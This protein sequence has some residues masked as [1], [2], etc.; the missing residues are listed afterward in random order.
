MKSLLGEREQAERPE[1]FGHLTIRL[2]LIMGATAL[3]LTLRSVDPVSVGTW[4]PFPMS[5]GA[6][7]GLPCIFCGM[8]RALHALLNGNVSGAIY[9]NWLVFPCLGT[10]VFIRLVWIVEVAKQPTNRNWNT[11]LLI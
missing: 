3:L 9:F 1:Y 11:V 4:T 5:C 6:V 10:V 2:A 7:T 8:T